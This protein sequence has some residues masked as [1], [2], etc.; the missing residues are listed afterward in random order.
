[1]AYDGII[2]VN[3]GTYTEV[4]SALSKEFDLIGE[5][6]SNGEPLPLVIGQITIDH[7]GSDAGWRI[8]NLRF[9]AGTAASLL[10]LKN[11]NRA[12]VS[13]CV[14]DGAGRFADAPAVNGL[15]FETAPNG[16][17]FPTVT[18]CVFSN[19]LY[20]AITGVAVDLTVADCVI[21]NVKS[22]MN[23]RGSRMSVLDSE[24]AVKA[25]TTTDTYG[26]RY[27]TSDAGSANGLN[28]Q[29]CVISVN[30]NDFVPAAGEYHCA[31]YL[32][33]G[34][35]G[36]QKVSNCALAGDIVNLSA[37]GITLDA[38]GNWWGSADPAVVKTAANGGAL[39][40]YSP[41]LA[42][43]TDTDN[44][45]RGFK[46]DFSSLWIDDDS[47]Q[48]GTVGG[49]QEGVNLVTAGGTVNVL[50]GTYA[51]H[52]AIDKAVS[53]LG[54]DK[55]TTFIDGSAD[56]VVVQISASEVAIKGFTVRNSGTD[57]NQHAGIA[58][59]GTTAALTGLVIEDNIVTNNA[60]GVALLGASATVQNNEIVNNARYG[61]VMSSSPHNAALLST[62]NTVVGNTLRG[63]ARDGI[64]C[65]AACSGNLITE[66]WIG[67]A[68]GTHEVGQLTALEGNGIYLWGSSNNVV[69]CNEIVGNA[70]YG[71]E[72]MMGDGN[73]IT[74]NVVTNNSAGICVR[75]GNSEQP[76]ASNA[77]HYNDVS[78]NTA[79][80]IA[81]NF[82][83][84]FVGNKAD[85]ALNAENNWFGHLT[86]PEHLAN[87]GGTGTATTD[88]VDF[89]PWLGLGTD[90]DLV[91]I[92]F[93]PTL[94]PVYYLPVG[95][96]F[97]TEPT[98]ALLGATLGTVTVQVTN[99]IG[100]V[101]TQFN[102]SIA[103]AI[104]NNPGAPVAGELSGTTNL[105]VANGVA[106]FDGLSIVK[107]TGDGYTLVAST[108]GLPA[109]TSAAF[110]IANSTPELAAIGNQTVNEEALLT[111]TATATDTTADLVAQTRTF[112]LSGTIPAG[113]SITTN[114]VFTWTPSESQ[115]G[116]NYTFTV[117]VTDNGTGALFDSEEITIT[118]AEVNVAPILSV[119]AASL[120]VVEQ[121][122]QALTFTATATD[123]D[124]VPTQAL[125]FSLVAVDG[126]TYPTGAQ[127]VTTD[128]ADGT[129]SGA[130]SWS[131]T[132]S[133]GGKTYIVDVVITDNGVNPVALSDT[134]RV[135]I[136]VAEIN[137][138]PV[139]ATIP[140]QSVN[141][142]Q[143]LTFTA[144]ATDQDL[145]TQTLAY[146]MA[147]APDGATLD[148]GSGAFAWTPTEAQAQSNYAFTV[149]VTDNGDHAMFDEQVVTIGAI[150]AAHSCPGYW[151]P[152]TNMVVS[153]SFAFAGEPAGLTWTP[154]LPNA[155]W[156]ITAADAGGNGVAEVS[157]GTAVVFT[158]LPTTSPA[159]F[160]YTVSVPGDQAVSNSLGAAVSFSGLTADVAP[161]AI[162]RYHSADYRRDLS[163]VTAGQFRKIDSTEIS[164]VLSYW[165]FGYKPDADGLDGFSAAADYAGTEAVHHSADTDK[166]WVVEG[167]ELLR[168]Q[169]Y[170]RGGGY[171]VDLATPDGYATDTNRAGTGPSLFTLAGIP[172]AAQTAPSGYNPGETLQVTYTLDTAGASLLALGW[173]PELPEGWMI[174]NVSGDAAPMFARNEIICGAAVLPTAT[175]T[176]TVTVRVPLTE[177]RTVTL[178]G[179][180]R[181]ITDSGYGV[182][183][184]AMESVTLAPVDGDSNGMAD[185]WERTFA[186]AAGS[187][188]PAA[189]LDGDTMSNLNEYR[190]GT[191][192]NDAASV[193][194]MVAVRPLADGKMQVSW[195]SVAG[196][197]YAVQ[198]AVGSPAAANFMTILTGIAADPTG[199]NVYVDDA[200]GAQ[201]RFY[202]V[203][204]QD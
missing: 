160:T 162:F 66:N 130:F 111:F 99:E 170:W 100:A 40:D 68:A 138:A 156:I 53:V 42:V 63:N 198:R 75:Y 83:A 173:A 195:A 69:S 86:G 177:T 78:G 115:G 97:N 175:A 16:N 153:N 96:Y 48:A 93:Q 120:S 23:M 122:A 87:P 103:L 15:A 125:T 106:I 12:A 142:G 10:S 37:T 76:F 85:Y 192:P 67:G 62:G 35:I 38:S 147:G 155:N 51:E 43:G 200:D 1:V 152:S 187:L 41:W 124:R 101:A 114:G 52:V 90:T 72:M 182:E 36:V 181:L 77:V 14:F 70:V 180:V 194:K 108:L 163:G 199:R 129:A 22:G 171:M 27:G 167:S 140:P 112:S 127:I 73:I 145:P 65:D 34:A 131:P 151:S 19:G 24:I 58:A 141:F 143:T 60:T 59:V 191:L 50:A 20:T 144:S 9:R 176:V 44:G 137:V 28:V 157:N 139:L 84:D 57:L 29:G 92:G 82:K 61:I 204:L 136:A 184:Y 95:L 168:V 107:G 80:G 91:A 71:I 54:A 113:A 18:D 118:V 183:S 3:A 55:A 17:T 109:V 49:I 126:Q 117:V 32:R 11:V 88:Y 81:L 8:E 121:P 5:T 25:V 185:A 21:D 159:V 203:V 190:C 186:G 119:P 26:I 79:F 179:A 128:N 56:D 64:Y 6:D 196:R 2:H 165:R 104:G 74:N 31:I 178:G 197:T 133:Q 161:I 189:D 45:A 47:P 116:S 135:S 188:D 158:T 98:G 201:A 105:V 30:Q 169:M 202:R 166:N 4:A 154:V 94:T 89:S 13:N 132:E 39:V 123:Q 174:E 148:P 102:G 7:P 149:T 110:D 164:R 46:G 146:T 150:S 193:L 33:K 172:A 134:Q